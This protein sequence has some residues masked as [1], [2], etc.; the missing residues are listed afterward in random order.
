MAT[1]YLNSTLFDLIK[2]KIYFWMNITMYKMNDPFILEG[3]DS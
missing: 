2:I 1:E 3:F